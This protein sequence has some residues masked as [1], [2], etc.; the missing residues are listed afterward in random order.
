MTTP[1]DAKGPKIAES[2]GKITFGHPLIARLE[3]VNLYND[4]LQQIGMAMKEIATCLTD[5]D[6]RI[7]RL[8]EKARKNK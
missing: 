8:E 6:T 3:A 4:I 5:L 7:K 2:I 1:L